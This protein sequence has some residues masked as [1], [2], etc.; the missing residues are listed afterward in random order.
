M[1]NYELPNEEIAEFPD[2]MSE[3]EIESVVAKEFP[4]TK[5]ATSQK[6]ESETAHDAAVRYGIK[7]PVAGLLNLGSRGG[8]AAGN[9]A[10]GFI[11]KIGGNLSKQESTDFSEMLGI[12]E[13]QKNLAEK[14]IQFAPE[15]GVSLALPETRLGKVGDILEKLPAWGKYLKKGV[16][17]AISQGAFG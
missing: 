13:A 2:D 3:S 9:L 10:I 6:S 1:K 11:N 17:N 4:P 14:L 7:D 16:G 5:A 15:I 8:T 12:P